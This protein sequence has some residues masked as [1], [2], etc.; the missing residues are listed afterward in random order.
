MGD[1]KAIEQLLAQITTITKRYEEIAK[2]SGETFNIFNILDLTSKELIHSRFIAMLLN[3]RGE[4]GMGSLF[5]ERFVKVIG[6]KKCDGIDCSGAEVEIEKS[7]KGGRRID[8]LIAMKNKKNIVIENKIYAGD[9]DEQLSCYYQYG[10]DPILLYLTL[11]ERFPSDASARSLKADKD[12]YCISYR[13]HILK[14]LEMCKKETANAPSLQT[15]INQYILL[16]KQLTGQSRSVEMDTEILKAITESEENFKAYWDIIGFGQEKIFTLFLSCNVRNEL[17]RIA[18]EKHNLECQE[19]TNE[20][21][22]EN[23]FK[24]GYGWIFKKPEWGKFEIWFY[25]G[26]NLSGLKYFILNR[27]KEFG[28]AW[29]SKKTVEKYPNWRNRAVFEKLFQPNN[30]VIK[31]IEGILEELVPEVEALVKQQ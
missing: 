7:I 13:E 4:H 8:I 28:E 2:V 16:V 1:F 11:D 29:N 22:P 17:K 12:Y 18:S 15:I 14:W 19:V 27:D 23:V 21:D 24:E 26:N 30:E 10:K 5:L 9:R 25:F 3:P 6:V 31:E 20:D